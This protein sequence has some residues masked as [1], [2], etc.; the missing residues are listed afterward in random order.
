MTNIGMYAISRIKGFIRPYMIAIV[1]WNKNKSN[2][3][4]ESISFIMYWVRITYENLITWSMHRICLVIF[5]FS[6]LWRFKW[7]VL[8]N[9]IR[10]LFPYIFISIFILKK[11]RFL[12]ISSYVYLQLSDNKR[13]FMNFT[14]S[15]IY[16]IGFNDLKSLY[17]YW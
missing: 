12:T 1:I 13:R 17:I 4:Y 5:I 2:V 11:G 9:P 8:L 16:M 15:N 3:L 14:I 7:H 10:D 6:I